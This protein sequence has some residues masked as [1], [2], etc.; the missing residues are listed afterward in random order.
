MSGEFSAAERAAVYRAMRER[1]DVR[2]DFV[3]DAVPQDVLLR[4]LAAAHMAPYVGLSQPWHFI[5]V[6]D[7]AIR[8]AVHAAFQD[9]NARAALDEGERAERYRALRLE[10]IRSAPL[11][12]CVTCDD[13]EKRGAGLGRQTMPETLRYS[14]VC[15]IANLWLA[16]RVEGLG[17]GWV[18]IIDPDA[19][20]EVLAIPAHIAIV[21]YLC[22]GYTSGFA[23]EP[24]LE[25][26]G[27]EARIPLEEA[28]DYE[29][30][31]PR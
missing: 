2:S 17:V 3:S 30:Y 20:R 10:G 15:A 28:I 9:A 4:V 11:G 25:R 13:G 24:D 18:S 7:P 8:D 16:A 21:A 6:R 1:R 19:L 23:L 29:R 14:S 27:W 26:A 31:D 22:V 5:A 12:I